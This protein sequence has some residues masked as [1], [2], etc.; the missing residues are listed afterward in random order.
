MKV[1]SGKIASNL[2]YTEKEN[3]CR[4]ER[5]SKMMSSDGSFLESAVA[6]ISDT[7][8]DRAQHTAT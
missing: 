1:S 3:D 5:L 8:V 7:V 6:F 4:E 2:F